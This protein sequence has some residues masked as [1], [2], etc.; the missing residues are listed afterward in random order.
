MS[1][2]DR[3]SASERSPS[4]THLRRREV[5]GPTGIS[6][7]AFGCRAM[8]ADSHLWNAAFPDTGSIPEAH[9]KARSRASFVAS[10]QSLPTPGVRTRPA[11]NNGSGCS[12]KGHSG[13]LSRPSL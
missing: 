10:G 5:A 6:K 1:V 3:Y 7:L 11:A 9:L 12:V 2:M 13:E 4:G 8:V